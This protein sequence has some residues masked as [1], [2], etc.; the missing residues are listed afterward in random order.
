M[1]KKCGRQ[2]GQKCKWQ[3]LIKVALKKKT[4]SKSCTEWKAMGFNVSRVVAIIHSVRLT[5]KKGGFANK[6]NH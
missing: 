4:S 2:R 3:S 5:E 1:I 6:S